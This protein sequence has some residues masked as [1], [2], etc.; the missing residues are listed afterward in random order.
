MKLLVK[1]KMLSWLDSYNVYF[2]DGK[3]AFEVRGQ[4]SW[5]RCQK[6]YDADGKEV[7]KVDEKI[8]SLTPTYII[9]SHGKKIGSIKR[10]LVSLIG[11]SYDIDFKGWH[12]DGNIMEW[13]YTIK[14]SKK[15]VIAK[16]RKELFN[17]T[18]T[19][20]M[21]ISNPND[22]LYVLMFVIAI[23]AEKS[24]RKEKEDKKNNK[25]KK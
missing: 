15:Q 3:K 20:S 19:Y 9:S 5:G 10:K 24:L 17:L 13:N 21:E 18:D 25:H 4:I 2:E 1:E 12:V 22:A 6:I 16:I 7:G 23:D 14:D 8:I 11:P